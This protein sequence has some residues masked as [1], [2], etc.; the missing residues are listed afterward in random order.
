MSNTVIDSVLKRMNDKLLQETNA[1]ISA[2]FSDKAEVENNL[3]CELLV[4][5][6]NKCKRDC[7]NILIISSD[8]IPDDC[9]G[10]LWVRPEDAKAWKK[11]K[12]TK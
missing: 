4:K 2:S 5:N 3:T 12:E 10:L 1:S 9:Y 7:K 6:I 8:L 11:N